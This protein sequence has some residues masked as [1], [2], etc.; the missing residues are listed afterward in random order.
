[1]ETAG[2]PWPEPGEGAASL[3]PCSVGG[4]ETEPRFKEGRTHL[5]SPR[6]KAKT[7]WDYLFLNFREYRVHC[8]ELS[9]RFSPH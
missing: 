2:L 9:I 6:D 1:M 8:N 7:L 4:T 3:S 5:V